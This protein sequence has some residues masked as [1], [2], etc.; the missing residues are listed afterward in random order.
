MNQISKL[1]VEGTMTKMIIPNAW[2]GN[3]EEVKTR[4]EN[5]KN[6]ENEEQR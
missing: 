4:F 5:Q 1:G 3:R 6:M 2:I